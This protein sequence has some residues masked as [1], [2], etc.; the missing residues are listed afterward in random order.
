LFDFI[1]EDDDGNVLTLK[2]ARVP[3]ALG[4]PVFLRATVVRHYSEADKPRTEIKDCVLVFEQEI[5]P[6]T[7]DE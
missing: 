2:A 5:A 7:V 3:V 1:F 6:S 4:D